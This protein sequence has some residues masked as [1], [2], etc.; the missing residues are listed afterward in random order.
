[1]DYIELSK[2]NI[3][4]Y[5]K[6]I[7]SFFEKNQEDFIFFHPHPLTW[8]GIKEAVDKKTKDIYILVFDE[9]LIGYGIL[10]GWDEGYLVPSLGIMISKYARGKGYSVPFMKQLHKISKERGA[11]KIRLTVYKENKTAISLYNKLGYT[12]SEKNDDELIGIKDL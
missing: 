8:E 10:R 2:E 4:K 1:M 11:E 5:K 6:E 12:F 9:K 3:G 7:T